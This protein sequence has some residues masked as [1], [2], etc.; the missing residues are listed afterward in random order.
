LIVLVLRRSPWKETNG[1]TSNPIA[2]AVKAI[3][4]D[5]TQSSL[6]TMPSAMIFFTMSEVLIALLSSNTQQL[7]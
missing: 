6:L 5:P 4:K 1:K 2:C 7:K 3:T